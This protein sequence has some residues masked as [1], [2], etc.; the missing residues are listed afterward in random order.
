VCAEPSSDKPK[1]EVRPCRREDLLEIQAILQYSPEAAAWTSDSLTE[2]FEQNMKYFFIALENH[3]V[4]GFVAGRQVLD[5]AE[6]LNLAVLPA[7][8]RKGAGSTLLR[9]LLEAFKREDVV[10]VFLEVR[11]SNLA[12]IS[13]YQKAGFQEI[14]KRPRYYQYPEEAALTFAVPLASAAPATGTG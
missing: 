11:E 13:F 7:G 4:I 1:A 8:R 3:K 5:E 6:V 10:K 9:V 2:I 12:A 14:G